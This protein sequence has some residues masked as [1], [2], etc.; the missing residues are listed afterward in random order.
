[1]LLDVTVESW[2][3][4]VTIVTRVYKN[5]AFLLMTLKDYL[6]FWAKI[7]CEDESV[8]SFVNKIFV[9]NAQGS[10]QV[11]IY[12]KLCLFYSTTKRT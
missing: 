5:V 6:L 11:K 9:I 7:R 8:V 4:S 3:V 12:I 1:M 10:L 2:L